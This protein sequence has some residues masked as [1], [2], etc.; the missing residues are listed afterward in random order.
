MYTWS[1]L[2]NMSD[3]FVSVSWN[4]VVLYIC[5]SIFKENTVLFFPFYMFCVYLFTV[6]TVHFTLTCIICLFRLNIQRFLRLFGVEATYDEKLCKEE[7]RHKCSIFMVPVWIWLWLDVWYCHHHKEVC[8]WG[9][10][11]MNTMCIEVKRDLTPLNSCIFACSI[12]NL[13]IF[14]PLEAVNC[15]FYFK[16]L[17]WYFGFHFIMHKTWSLSWYLVTFELDLILLFTPNN[18]SIVKFSIIHID[19]D[20]VIPAASAKWKTLW[21]AFQRYYISL[22]MALTEHIYK[23][24]FFKIISDL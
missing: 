3:R 2:A 13:F 10:T 15:T 5:T 20:Y 22:L 4:M 1:S 12:Y 14:F 19:C 6:P 21:S 23:R 16:C 7:C 8:V 24:C 11:V 9:N 17:N 18:L